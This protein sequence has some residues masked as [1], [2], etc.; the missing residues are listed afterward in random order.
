ME[1]QTHDAP[2]FAAVQASDPEASIATLPYPAG[3][4]AA[5][6][7]ERAG[8]RLQSA[9]VADPLA[10]TVSR[11]AFA[12]AVRLAFDS[13]QCATPA[14][15]LLNL[16]RF[17]TV[18]ETLGHS[19][20][21]TV[22]R[23]A[24][25]RLV[26]AVRESDT[27]AW[28]GGD[29]F[30]VLLEASP[31]ADQAAR[32][33]ERIIE[34]VQRTYLIEDQL[35][36]IGVSIGIAVGPG[37]GA[38][39]ESLMRHADLALYQAKRCGGAGFKFFDW[40]M[41]HRA[42]SRR[43]NELELR[44]ALSLRQF[45]VYYQP[46]VNI[47]SNRL[48][49]FEAL[50]RWKHPDRGFVPPSEFIPL[51]E[52]IGVIVPLGDWVLRTACRQAVNQWPPDV[53]VAVNVSPAQFV[54]GRFADSVHNALT[55]TGLPGSRLEIEVTEGLLLRPEPAI[56]ETLA[57]LREMKVRFAMDDFGTGYA[58]LSQLAH[59]HFDKIKIDRSLVG[60]EG[61]TAKHRAI[62]RA[63]A[64]LAEGLGVS[65]IAE[66]VETEEQLERL[67]QDGCTSVQG[68]LFGRPVPADQTAGIVARFNSPGEI[69]HE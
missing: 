3:A 23:L 68:Y 36:N 57:A 16:D 27:V 34:I 58:S 9:Q 59:F 52:E 32:I 69:N 14:V 64:A 19:A 17:K 4:P 35:V 24:A 15:M 66:G 48:V 45:E 25:E 33:A 47:R 54:T 61:H 31:S 62:V 44:R 28:L 10:G 1:T 65:T 53:S 7:L 30:A 21:D 6:L 20:G 38:D 49:G 42:Q 60:S 18:N 41:D 55:S 11:R 26:S 63:I 46:Q 37:H 29:E 56:L 40:D 12:N 51:S 43:R 39:P 67:R 5:S 22:L 13:E 8:A 2:D 50:V